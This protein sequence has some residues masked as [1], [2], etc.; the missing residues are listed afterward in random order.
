MCAVL[1]LAV[2]FMKTSVSA[3]NTRGTACAARRVYYCVYSGG[4][5]QTR[6]SLGFRTSSLFRGVGGL[7]GLVEE[8]GVRFFVVCL[9]RV[10]LAS[11]ELSVY[12]KLVSNL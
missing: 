4:S 8:L 12:P 2:S 10:A 5:T 3:I 11:L 6:G 9:C 1:H 7:A